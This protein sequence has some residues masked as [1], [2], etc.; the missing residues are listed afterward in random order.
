MIPAS[1]CDADERV[2]PDSDSSDEEEGAVQARPTVS[3]GLKPERVIPDSDSSDDNDEDEEGAKAR[4]IA[5]RIPHTD[6][7]DDE[8]VERA[9]AA[10]KVGACPLHH[11]FVSLLQ[12]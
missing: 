5:S 6:G 2:I 7:T 4:P 12:L 8:D 10:S 1:D 9:L 11:R 3:A